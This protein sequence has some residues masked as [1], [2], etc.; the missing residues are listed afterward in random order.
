MVKKALLIGINYKGTSAQL[1]G[2]INDVANINE[3]LT[4]QSGYVSANIRILTDDTAVKPTRRNI[5]ESM[6]WLVEGNKTG[7]TLVFHFSGHGTYTKD[8]NGDETDGKDEALCPLDYEKA[9]LILDDWISDSILV[10]VVEN[11]TFISFSDC[12]HSGT[13]MDL[14]FNYKSLCEYKKGQIKRGIVYDESEWTDRFS[15]SLEKSNA[16][17]GNV[18]L[19]SGCEDSEKSVDARING[20]SQGAFTNCLLQSLKSSNGLTQNLRGLLKEINCRLEIRGFKQNS[21]LSL[22]K[23]QLLEG[24]LDL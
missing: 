21:Q 18:C 10:K 2:C 19:F 7:D 8:K 3:F 4:T 15:F 12:C 11:A 20:V 5:E 16:I 9:G 13:I 1:N 17:V 24:P 22:S 6:R 23:M 14:R